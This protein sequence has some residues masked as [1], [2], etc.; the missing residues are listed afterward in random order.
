[1]IQNIMNQ[2]NNIKYGWKDK[3][4]IIHYDIDKAFSSNYILEAPEEVLESN[5]GVCWDQVELERDL[6]EKLNIEFNTYFI[7]HYDNDRCP[8]HTFL[9]YKDNNSYYWFEHSWEVFRGVHEYKSEEDALID[10]KKKFIKHELN[11]KF[12]N[13]NLCLYK[14][15]KP[16]YGINC[17]DFYIHCENGENIII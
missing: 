6:F 12:I 9:I 17:K 5:A 7:V 14:Y 13:D 15:T 16:K 11:D 8:T 3:D 4:G 1:M 10:I 2:M